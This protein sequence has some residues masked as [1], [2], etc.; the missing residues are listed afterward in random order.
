MNSVLI[1]A[2]SE[3]ARGTLSE[4]TRLCGLSV[5]AGAGGGNDAR[6]WLLE[7][8]FSEAMLREAYDR[9]VDST[10]RMNL[11]YINRIL[12]RW[13]K[14]GVSNPQQASAEQAAK[15][16]ARAQAPETSFDLDEYERTSGW[17][18]TGKE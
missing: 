15:S 9:C 12:E 3:N 11:S 2:G 8:N 10:G 13:H 17:G 6:R 5:Q 14:A 16:A 18:F 1:V 4:L 7:W